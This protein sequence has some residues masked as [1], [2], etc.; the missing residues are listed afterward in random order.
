MFDLSRAES[1]RLIEAERVRINGLTVR[2]ASAKL[3]PGMLVSVRGYGRFRFE[4]TAGE[5]RRGRLR[6]RIRKY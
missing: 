5:T 2:S 4:E 6:I 3:E 1:Q